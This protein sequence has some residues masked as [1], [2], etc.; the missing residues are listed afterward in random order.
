MLLTVIFPFFFP[1]KTFTYV[2]NVK[3]LRVFLSFYCMKINVSLTTSIK[4]AEFHTTT[5]TSQTIQI[6]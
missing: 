3:S 6:V 5:K 2:L 1:E 4:V